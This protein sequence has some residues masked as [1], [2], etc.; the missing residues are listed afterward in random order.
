M[1]RYMNVAILDRSASAEQPAQQRETE[2]GW[3][4]P[5]WKWPYGTKFGELNLIEKAYWYSVSLD[6]KKKK[7]DRIRTKV[8][9]SKFT[10]FIY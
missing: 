4:N 3:S 7:G 8:Q 6:L 9:N 1:A 5:D 2:G 10:I